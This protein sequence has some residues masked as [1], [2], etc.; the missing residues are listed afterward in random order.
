MIPPVTASEQGKAQWEGLIGS[1]RVIYG[2]NVQ[3][4]DSPTL[5][6]LHRMKTGGNLDH[7]GCKSRS[8]MKGKGG[9][10]LFT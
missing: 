7:R 9:N 8:F 5:S 3:Y 6:V 1:K 2:F 10:E 4:G